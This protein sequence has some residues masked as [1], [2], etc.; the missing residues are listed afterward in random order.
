MDRIF[1]RVDA[2]VGLSA[3]DENVTEVPGDLRINFEE[4]QLVLQAAAKRRYP[5]AGWASRTGTQPT[6]I[7]RST[8]I[9]GPP[10]IRARGT[11]LLQWSGG[12]VCHQIGSVHRYKHSP[13]GEPCPDLGSSA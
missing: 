5:E 11:L 9:D 8:E 13:L 6:F 2:G 12:S 1:T 7:R 3:E 4:F 10:F